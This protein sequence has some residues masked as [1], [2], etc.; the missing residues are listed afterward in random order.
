MLVVDDDPQILR[1]LQITL[2]FEG[3]QVKTATT[4]AEAL[5]VATASAPKAII[6]DLL[7]PDGRGTDVCQKLRERSTAPV[8]I[9]SAVDDQAERT[10]ALDA[11]A[12]D[13]LTKPFT[14]DELLARLGA[15]RQPTTPT[16]RATPQTDELRTA[17]R[18]TR[19]RSLDG[20][21]N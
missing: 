5:A 21:Y 11:G 7:L 19:S 15:A 12:D 14:I 16:S 10:A 6:L 9:M 8:L 2:S 4:A 13:Y 3:Y 18:S 20:P 17:S 1:A